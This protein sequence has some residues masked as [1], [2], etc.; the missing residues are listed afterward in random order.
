VPKAQTEA[1]AHYPATLYSAPEFP[2]LGDP[3]QR[4]RL[5]PAAF[6]SFLNIMRIWNIRD[7]DARTLL[8]GVSN[9]SF[10]S[11]KSSGAKLLDE[12]KLLRISLLLGIFKSLNILFSSPLADQWVRLKNTNA[13][14]AGRTPLSYMLGGGAPA[15]SVLRQLLDARR[16]G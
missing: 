1:A 12:D 4:R 9:G 6:R 14:F 11:W 8:G 10:Y 3:D 7:E 15:M 5:S 16:G 13:L 2:H